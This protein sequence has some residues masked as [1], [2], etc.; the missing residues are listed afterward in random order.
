VASGGAFG[1]SSPLEL[2]LELLLESS[3]GNLGAGSVGNG[4]S[5]AADEGVADP[6]EGAGVS[7]GGVD[8]LLA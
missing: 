5:V 6:V 7:G 4:C 2:E 8:G 3:P 1:S